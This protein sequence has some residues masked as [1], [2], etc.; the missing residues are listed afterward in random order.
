MLVSR[1]GVAQMQLIEI[2]KALCYES[3]LLILDEPTATLTSKEVERLFEILRRLKSKGVTILYISHRL[4]EIAEIGDRVTVLRDGQL[5]AT[6]PLAGLTIPEI[7][8]MMVGRSMEGEHAFRE[9]VVVSGEALRVEGLRRNAKTPEVSLRVGKGEIV[10]VAGLVGSGR[11]ETMA[12]AIFGADPKIAGEIFVEGVRV[13]IA[14]PKDAVRHGLC[15]MTEDR[16]GQGLLLGMSCAHNIT[17]T[18]LSENLALRRSRSRRRARRGDGTRRG[19]A[20]QDAFDR[21][22][23]AQLF[24]RQ[25][26][27][28]RHREVAVPRLESPDLR[29]ADAR[30]RRRRAGPRST[31]SCGA[32]PR[33]AAAFSSFRPTCR[34]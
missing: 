12:R 20:H 3:K 29:R 34:S 33:R 8:H 14:S 28:G 16:K 10:G 18:D 31:I 21:S 2:A 6:R 9:D 7:V 27:E 13:K 30:H 17:I 24:R 23:G 15:L 22:A 26:A 5:V 4:H 19:S 25:P 32:W 11:T 1:L